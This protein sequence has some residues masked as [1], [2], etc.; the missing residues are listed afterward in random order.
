ML[1]KVLCSTCSYILTSWHGKNF[2][3][4]WWC[5]QMETFSAWL[6]ICAG[7]SPVPGEFPANSPHKG[8]W[9]GAL[10]FCLIRVWINSWVNN[11]EAGDLRRY[12]AHCDVIVM[13]RRWMALAKS[14]L[15][16]ALMFSLMSALMNCWINSRVDGDLKRP[17]THTI[18]TSSIPH[19][20][21]RE[22]P[23]VTQP[24]S[25]ADTGQQE[26]H[27]VSPATSIW[28]RFLL[29][30]IAIRFRV[31][32]HIDLS[33]NI[34]SLWHCSWRVITLSARQNV[35]NF[36]DDIFIDN[37]LFNEKKWI[38]TKYSL[39]SFYEGTIN[40][41][42]ALDQI[43]SRRRTGDKLLSEW[44]M[45]L[46]TDI[47]VRH[48]PWQ[49]KSL[50][51]NNQKTR[52]DNSNIS[53]GYYTCSFDRLYFWSS[54]WHTLVRTHQRKYWNALIVDRGHDDLGCSCNHRA[55]PP[56]PLYSRPCMP[57][58][59]MSLVKNEWLR[60]SSKCCALVSISVIPL[61]EFLHIIVFRV[62]WEN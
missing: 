43:M 55:A 37:I 35:Q 22:P 46:L 51:S 50:T 45:A 13:I 19:A 15:C 41:N 32:S 3:I 36:T 58:Y 40:N 1:S 9:R 49:P 18:L 26:F 28:H 59:F 5:H 4:T 31:N 47:Y 24:Y 21:I 27:L 2:P 6:A 61:N 29:T 16:R 56:F 25:I 42:T 10:M 44:A 54:K 53:S 62:G 7:N 48:S 20:E 33:R 34:T 17:D 30:F 8:Q 14:Q 12:L 23:Q 38:S 39:K 11:C 52:V 60:R 57:Y